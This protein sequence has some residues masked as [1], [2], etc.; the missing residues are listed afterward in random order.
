MRSYSAWVPTNFT[1]AMP[2]RYCISTTRR[3]LLPPML[4]T[5]RCRPTTL[6]VAKYDL[7]ECGDVHLPRNA[8]SC[9]LSNDCPVIR[10]APYGLHFNHPWLLNPCPEAVEG[11]AT[12][13]DL[14]PHALQRSMSMVEHAL[15]KKRP[16]HAHWRAVGVLS[17]PFVCVRRRRIP[18]SL[19][20]CENRRWR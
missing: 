5:T 8:S 4:N 10:R 3:Y 1:H 20:S 16:T 6:A 15:E 11:S 9:Q 7:T 13:F 12:I 18:L 17:T 14:P 19:F 2:A